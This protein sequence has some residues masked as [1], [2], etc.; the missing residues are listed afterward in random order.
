M[1]QQ[2]LTVQRNGQPVRLNTHINPYSRK[3]WRKQRVQIH[4]FFT[5]IENDYRILHKPFKT[6]INVDNRLQ[7]KRTPLNV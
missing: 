5:D 4:N 6:V 2:V 7:L 3:S 1:K